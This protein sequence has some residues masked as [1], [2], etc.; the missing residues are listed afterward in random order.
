M[1]LKLII[2]TVDSAEPGNNTYIT[3]AF[4]AGFNNDIEELTVRHFVSTKKKPRPKDEAFLI[5]AWQ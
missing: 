5:D 4:T 2:Q 3:A 1:Y